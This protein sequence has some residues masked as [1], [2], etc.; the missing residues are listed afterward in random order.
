MLA[1]RIMRREVTRGTA[2]APTQW[3]RRADK[4]P[5]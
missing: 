4:T 1:L 2:Q 3:R 5:G